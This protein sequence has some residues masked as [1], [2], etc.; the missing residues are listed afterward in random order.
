MRQQPRQGGDTLLLET[1]PDFLTKYRHSSEF[2]LVN[3]AFRM[4]PP[5][6]DPLRLFA[7]LALF[8][9]TI[10]LNRCAGPWGMLGRS[11]Q[12]TSRHA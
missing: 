11:H 10:V 3:D 6:R 7:A 2:A 8:I 4:A 1:G 12:P 5:R 9:T